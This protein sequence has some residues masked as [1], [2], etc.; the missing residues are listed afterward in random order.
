VRGQRVKP[1]GG[2]ALFQLPVPGGGIEFS[3]PG[4]KCGKLLRREAL[5]GGLDFLNAHG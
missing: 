4:A 3:K 5:D 2:R 1:A